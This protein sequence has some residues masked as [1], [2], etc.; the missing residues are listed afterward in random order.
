MAACWLWCSFLMDQEKNTKLAK[1]LDARRNNIPSTTWFFFDVSNN[2]CF[3]NMFNTINCS[4]SVEL[5]HK[6]TVLFVRVREGGCWP[7]N[8]HLMGHDKHMDNTGRSVAPVDQPVALVAQGWREV[9]WTK[10]L[11][12]D[13]V[14]AGANQLWQDVWMDFCSRLKGTV[15]NFNCTV[16]LYIYR[17]L[18]KCPKRRRLSPFLMAAEKLVKHSFSE[19]MF[20][21]RC[22]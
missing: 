5:C 20:Q 13:V 12:A 16:Q 8:S 4:C 22:L 7:Q 3:T 21:S 18:F 11:V 1:V 19:Q 9:S 15:F 17:I 14:D 6:V 2:T 10:P